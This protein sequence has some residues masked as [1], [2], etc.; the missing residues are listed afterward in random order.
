[1]SIKAELQCEGTGS[2]IC[3]KTGSKD[4]CNIDICQRTR[5][6]EQ[7][8]LKNNTFLLD[9]RK[10]QHGAKKRAAKNE[11]YFVTLP[12]IFTVLMVCLSQAPPK[13]AQ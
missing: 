11:T 10:M 3:G 1:M 7:R 9:S 5:R 12:S 8:G 13:P 4:D 6:F 2:C